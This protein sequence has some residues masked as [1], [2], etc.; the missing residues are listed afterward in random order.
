MCLNLTEARGLENDEEDPVPL[1]EE[2]ERNRKFQRGIDTEGPKQGF[3]NAFLSGQDSDDDVRWA[4]VWRCPFYIILRCL[5][6]K[7]EFPM[8]KPISTL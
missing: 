2:Q 6:S 3:P 1:I 5:S 4:S 8:T 7:L